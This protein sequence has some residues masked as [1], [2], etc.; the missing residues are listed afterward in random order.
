MLV[1]VNGIRPCSCFFP[2]CL[3]PPSPELMAQLKARYTELIGQGR[4]PESMTFDEFY[5]FWRSS[6]RSEN[7]IGLDDGALVQGQSTDPQ[8]IARPTKV[9]KGV[10]QT[11][12]LL[13]DFEDRPASIGRSSSFYEQMLFGDDGIFLTGSMREFY[14]RISGFSA[15]TGL[16]IDIQGKVHGWLRMPQPS[17]FYTNEESGMGS[18]PQN[19][20]GMAE[21]AVK[22]ALS[23]GIDFSPYDSLGE[24]FVTALFIIHAGRGAEETGSK[25]DVWSLKW[26]TPKSI[27]VAA[28]GLKVQTFLTVPEDCNMGVCAHEWG[29]L[30]ARWADYYDTGRAENTRSNGLGD[31]CLMAS[32][33]WGQGGLTPTFAS[34]MLRMFHGW[35]DTQ[36]VDS[37]QNDIVLKPA[38]EGGNLVFIHN[39]KY[40]RDD[41][42]YVLVEYRRR[43]EQD[44]F[45][46]DEGVAIYVIDEAIDNVNDEQQLAIELLQADGRRDLAKIF[47]RGNR[48][49]QNDLY[50]SL[51]NT[52]LNTIAG[53]DTNPALNLPGGS[54]TGITITVKGNPGD[55]QMLIDVAI[56]D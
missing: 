52:V 35:V 56:S 50:P 30:A 24:D 13:V 7:F 10:I 21:D 49:D 5:I 48:G 38:A 20:Q 47:G 11:L 3:V 23:Q 40:M 33:S 37:S 31:F 42:Q 29:H 27:Q 18:Y 8:L 54:W 51:I 6:R 14:R 45:L 15:T 12:V 43:R 28:N 36:L 4:L 16:G 46:P 39:S 26:V 41:K 32:G 17:S 34:G 22:V 44:A 1:Q 19:A 2:R 25:E 9:L 55:N 53:K